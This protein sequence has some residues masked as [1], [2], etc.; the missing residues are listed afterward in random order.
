MTRHNIGFLLINEITKKVKPKSTHKTKSYSCYEIDYG[1]RRVILVK[2][3]MYMNRSGEVLEKLLEKYSIPLKNLLVIVDDFNLPFG[4]LRF[5][6]KGS[7]GGHNGLNSII[8]HLQDNSFPRLRIGIG[9]ENIQDPI[10]F[11]LGR[12]NKDERKRLPEI[13]TSSVEACFFYL[14]YGIN[15]TMNQYNQESN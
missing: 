14:R 8:S 15:K 5:R 4:K 11:V 2:P 3:L 10:Q 7:S 13:I 6:S 9:Y 12:F 1:A